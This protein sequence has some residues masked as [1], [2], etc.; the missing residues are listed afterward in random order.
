MPNA[1]STCEAL[2]GQ[3]YV[4]TRNVDIYNIYGICYGTSL[5]PALEGS[6]EKTQ[7]KGWS[8]RDYTPW[9]FPKE[10]HI[11]EL[12]SELGIEGGSLPPCTFGTPLMEYFDREDVRTALHITPGSK[13]WEMCTSDIDYTS[14]PQASQ[15]IYE[16]LH[17]KIRM[18]HFSGDVDGA[19]G[20]IGTQ[21]W[22]DS[23]NWEITGDWAQWKFNS[24]VAGYSTEYVD[25]FHFIIVHGAGHMVP[26]DKPP[27]ALQFL[28]NWIDKKPLSETIAFN[29]GTNITTPV[30]PI[31]ANVLP[32]FTPLQ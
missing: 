22:I 17:G 26:E 19:V 8:A 4:L 14:L 6:E 13:A 27:Q 18:M 21:N 30:L 12:E 29:N 5:N 15:W 2:Y 10:E 7:R 28:Y 24:Q 11:K 9:A 3:F 31:D 1:S 23:L 25:D 16:E 32:S 20:T